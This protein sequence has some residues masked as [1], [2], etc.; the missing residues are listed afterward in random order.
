MSGGVDDAPGAWPALR[1]HECHL[2]P[3]GTRRHLTLNREWTFCGYGGERERLVGGHG[4][5]ELCALCQREA[6]E[7]V[8]KLERLGVDLPV[9]A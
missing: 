4:G 3:N 1:L 8:A 6:R 9:P 5:F 2:V 7:L